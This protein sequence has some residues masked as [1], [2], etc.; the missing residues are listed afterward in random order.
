MAAGSGATEAQ[1]H[2]TRAESCATSAFEA[3]RR[4]YKE[5]AGHGYDPNNQEYSAG[6]G[7]QPAACTLPRRG[8]GRLARSIERAV[9]F[10]A[11][12]G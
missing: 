10:A 4:S 6:L 11:T 1:G 8:L 9:P 7:F 5:F 3:N 2:R 12:P